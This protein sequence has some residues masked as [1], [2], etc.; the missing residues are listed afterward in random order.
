MLS[1]VLTVGYNFIL[2]M[3]TVSGRIINS[4]DLANDHTNKIT[5]PSCSTLSVYTID[6]VS[7]SSTPGSSVVAHNVM[8]VVAADVLLQKQTEYIICNV[9]KVSQ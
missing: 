5:A 6:N 7:I 3:A 1:I 9:F 8:Q 4:V 2:C